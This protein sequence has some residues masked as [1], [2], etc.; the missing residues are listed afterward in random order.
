MVVLAI[1]LAEKRDL[2]WWHP[3]ISGDL[4][5]VSQPAWFPRN[6]EKGVNH[7]EPYTYDTRVPLILAGFG[8]RAGRP[9][10]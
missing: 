3:L 1:N 9:G 6:T 7:A 8:V 5:I 10:G 4:L 2:Y